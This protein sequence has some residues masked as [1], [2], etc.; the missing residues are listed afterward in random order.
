MTSTALHGH[1]RTRGRW[2]PYALVL[3][4]LSSLLSALQS[5]PASAEPVEA[6]Y[7]DFSY[8][9]SISAPTGDKP[10][11]KLWYNDNSWWGV[12]YNATSKQWEIY[13]FDVASQSWS[14]TGTSLETRKPVQADTLWDGSKLYVI[15]HVKDTSSLADV[16]VGFTRLSYDAA[17]KTYSIDSGFPVT[18][19]T[20]KVES[21]VLDKDS[22]GKLWV[23]FT[24]TRG[25]G[26]TVYVT[27]TTTSDTKW[28]APYE[29]PVAGANNLKSDDIATLVATGGKIGVLWSNQLDQRLYFATHTDGTDDSAGSWQRK[30]ALCDQPRCADDH[31]NIKSVDAASGKVF[32]VV[33]TSL[34]DGSNA[35]PGDP[36]IMLYKFDIATAAYTSRVAWTVAENVTRAI[37]VLDTTNSRAYTF[38]AGPCCS[39]GIVY[40]KS[41]PFDLSSGF[42][43]GLGTPV[44]KSAADPKINNV[45]S[46]KQSVSS[47]SGLLILAGDDSTRY[48]VHAYLP[49][50]GAPADTT[51]PTVTAVAPADGATGVSRST[52]VT[53]TF[54]EPINPATVSSSTVTLAGPAGTVPASVAAADQTATLTPG[55]ALAAGTRYTVTVR[56][57]SGGVKDL[58]GNALAADKKWSF[59]TSSSTPPPSTAAV[60]PIADAYVRSSSPTKNLGTTAILS[61]DASPV[62]VTY[63][64][65]DLSA[66]AGRTLTGATLRLTVGDNSSTGRQDVKLVAD[67]SW[68]ETGLT[69]T[70]RPAPTTTVGSLAKTTVNTAY[71]IPLAVPALSGQLGSVLSLALDSPSTDAVVFASREASTGRP[72]L[73]L[74]F[75]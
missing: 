36:L 75:S 43:S 24:D 53:A 3:L 41:V 47:K 70:N 22:T 11:S 62:D 69:Y 5:P 25:T 1:A 56:G 68:T 45:T 60:V 12:L 27:H 26:R 33:K 57:G 10:Q 66:Y 2:L 7:R 34:N 20:R 52:P 58:A 16:R 8:G 67:N 29:L 50:G 48:Y 14:T 19:A 23:V 28:I 18:A 30:E 59:T 55:S 74:T 44:I 37:V 13:K 72:E 4:L 42:P 38:A 73:V 49:L 40:S 61:V 39:G 71:E 32:A 15:F 9:S 6:G 35:K 63:L 51:P 17:R 46:T 21:A 65:F 31:L 54:S 64:K